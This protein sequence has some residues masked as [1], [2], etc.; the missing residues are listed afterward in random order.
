MKRWVKPPALAEE[1]T[2]LAIGQL[3]EAVVDFA[4]EELMIDRAP[5]GRGTATGS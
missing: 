3:N 5:D 2:H 4:Q 1:L